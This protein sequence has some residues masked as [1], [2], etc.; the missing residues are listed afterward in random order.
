MTRAHAA[1]VHAICEQMLLSE[2]QVARAH[3]KSRASA[4]LASAAA[5]TIDV[6]ACPRFCLLHNL[7]SRRQLDVIRLL[8]AITGATVPS[9]VMKRSADSD[10]D[11]Q[12]Q[13]VIR[14]FSRRQGCP[15]S[16]RVHCAYSL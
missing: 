7:Q 11:L 3:L 5:V 9:V 10:Y 6:D 1:A 16:L 13:I 12:I 2:E 8:G 15:G 14:R 4:A